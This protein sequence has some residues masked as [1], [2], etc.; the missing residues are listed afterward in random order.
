M[1]PESDESFG[2]VL[3]VRYGIDWLPVLPHLIGIQSDGA[4]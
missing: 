1:K 2:H 4:I 3:D